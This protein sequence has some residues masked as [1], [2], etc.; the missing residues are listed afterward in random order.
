MKGCEKHTSAPHDARHCARPVQLLLQCLKHFLTPPALP[1]QCAQDL[2]GAYL[3]DML[4]LFTIKF[5]RF[6]SQPVRRVTS[7]VRD[8]IDL[9]AEHDADSPQR[10]QRALEE[11]E[12]QIDRGDED[13][14][15]SL[16]DRTAGAR[17][18]GFADVRY[19][20]DE[21]PRDEE[22][23]DDENGDPRALLPDFPFIPNANAMH[24]E[25]Q[26]GRMVA[27]GDEL[28]QQLWHAQEQ[29]QKPI[30]TDHRAENIRENS[31]DGKQVQQLQ[32][33][34]RFQQ[35]ARA[36]RHNA[37]PMVEEPA[38]LDEQHR[39]E[40]NNTEGVEYFEAGENVNFQ[41][42]MSKLNPSALAE[43]FAAEA[44]ASQAGMH[45][46][47][48][49]RNEEDPYS[50]FSELLHPSQR[51]R[52]PKPKP[53]SQSMRA[54]KDS[55][56]K[57][58]VSDEEP[59]GQKMPNRSR[60]AQ[61]LQQQDQE[62]NAHRR[63]EAFMREQHA[64]ASENAGAPETDAGE[65][66]E[67]N[68]A[69][70]GTPEEE[71]EF[72]ELAFEKKI[73]QGAFGDV[74]RGQYKGGYVA[75][76][77]L[78][79]TQVKQ[80]A[81]ND[82]RKEITLLCKLR[83]PN[84]VRLIGVCTKPPELCIV[85]EYAGRGCLYAIVHNP[86]VKLQHSHH[87]QWAEETARG[88]EYLHRRER[89]K[90]PIIHRDLKSGNLLVDSQWK[91]KISD[92]GLARIRETSHAHTQV[93]TFAWMAPEVLENK[94]YAEPADM[95]SFAIVMWECLTRQEPF[96]GMH[97]MQIMR[98]I[99]RGERPRM[100]A[101]VHSTLEFVRIMEL[102]WSHNPEHRPT[103]KSVLTALQ[104]INPKETVSVS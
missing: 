24:E 63:A 95:Y 32:T 26:P 64:V 5:F 55:T 6:L 102:C 35:R 34:G 69:S 18:L 4:Q 51:P 68:V 98:A 57:N 40:E 86:R 88:M 100:P 87:V 65:D 58:G 19:D 1:K 101:G 90:P 104:K 36:A 50:Q 82:F 46:D 37:T 85:M 3:F 79:M 94:P 23:E 67:D 76:K 83:H 31:E 28:L 96:K 92:F 9:S 39:S 77:R 78:R 61:E 45:A 93:G 73:G 91:I 33:Q 42:A 89:N 74:M 81:V 14:E 38:A 25:T 27:H 49:A 11:E 44:T 66:D 7:R 21:E 12:A 2:V 56:P 60:S 84:V 97:P 70:V 16:V 71:I 75:V 59:E 41:T 30:T 103:F 43:A 15:D 8:S 17:G 54:S 72:E 52:K 20:D 80:A 53:Q 29:N 48:T 10:L 99:D 62:Q 47:V 13:T 22:N